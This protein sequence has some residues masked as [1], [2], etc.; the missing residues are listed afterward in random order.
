MNLD[1][2][3]P[4]DSIINRNTNK[5]LWKLLQIGAIVF[6][7]ALLVIG[8]LTLWTTSAET[9]AY[10]APAYPQENIDMLLQKEKLNESDYQLLFQQTGLSKSGVDYLFSQNRQ[11]ELLQLQKYYFANVKVAC[12]ANTIITREERI[13]ELQLPEEEYNIY[14]LGRSGTSESI[15]RTRVSI[16]YVE[17][18]DILITFNCHAFG[19]RNG[20]AALVLD[21]E[22]RLALEARVLGT[23]SAIMP[24]AHWERYP[25]FAVLRLKDATKE[26]RQEIA[27]YAAEHLVNIPYRLEAGIWEWTKNSAT[28]A[29]ATEVLSGT[30]CAHLVR[31]AYQQFGYDL[32]SDGGIIVTPRDL[33]E[34]AK[35]EIV[36]VYGMHEN[37][38]IP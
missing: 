28:G 29:G 1:K 25:S 31:Y 24:M 19:W 4:D 23:D 32:D 17:A 27:D 7:L 22:K 6:F 9:R 3:E 33:Y 10:I 11:Q 15:D 20:H 36:Q 14:N 2:K 38:K 30:H 18:G 21:G 13:K 26:Q 8:V 5:R 16:P 37:I 12:N 35:L 34:S